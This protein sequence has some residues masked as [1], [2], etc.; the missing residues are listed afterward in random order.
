MDNDAGRYRRF[1]EGDDNGLVEIIDRYH[2]GL[3]LYLNSIVK[4]ICVAE[5]IMQ[6]TF[7]KLAIK[8][9]RFKGKCEFKTWLYA[10]AKN[11]AFD[12]LRKKS[13]MDNVPVDEDFLPSD[14]EDIEKQYLKNEQKIT[15]HRNLKE[16]T[17]EYSQVLY[18]MYFEDFDTAQVAEIMGKSKKQIGDLHY[19]AKQSLKIKMEK[20]G[21]IYEEL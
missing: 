4:N 1:L 3:S 9:P 2:E 10:I 14:E 13:R 16:L 7:V 19:R 20:E 21:F 12:F 11:C 17:P 6:N 15:L 8:K 5:E 18:L